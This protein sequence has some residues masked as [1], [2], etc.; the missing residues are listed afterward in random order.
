MRA[1][2]YR[3]APRELLCKILDSGEMVMGHAPAG[4]LRGDGVVPGDFVELEKNKDGHKIKNVEPRK[5]EIF[6]IVVR[7]RKKKVTAANCDLLVIIVSI[8]NPAYKRGIVDR[9]LMRAFQWGIDA[10]IVFNKMDEHDG[11]LDIVFEKDR[12]RKLG[13][14]CFEISAK[15]FDYK[16]QYLP[17]GFL[18][19]KQK[20]SKRTAIFLGQSGVGKSKS[21]NALTEGAVN[22]K[23]RSIGKV[24]KG[25]HTTTWSEVID[26]GDFMLIDSPGIRSF[27]LD[28]LKE[29]E[30]IHYFP[31]IAELSVQCRFPDCNHDSK[32]Q[33][34][35]FSTLPGD[36]YQTKL[37]L[38]R[39]KSFQKIKKEV[40]SVPFWEKR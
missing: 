13:V 12:L 16:N 2:I 24:G 27:A 28:D 32:A 40:G 18:Q 21:I 9:F 6:R 35:F 37:L 25:V 7:E 8:S 31:D 39:L 14:Q 38:S 4:L 23:T 29:E 10:V 19:F 36:D 3:S 33:G 17:D 15:Y 5:N 26:I 34:C 11:K 22:L 1:R 20:L 30:V